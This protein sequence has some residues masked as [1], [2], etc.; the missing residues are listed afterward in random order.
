M[1]KLSSPAAAL[2]EKRWRRKYYRIYTL[3]FW[4]TALIVYACFI[5]SGY[6]LIWGT[7]GWQQHFKALCYY[8]EY[9]RRIARTLL[10]E[11]RLV[12]PNWDFTFGEG[13][14]VLNTLHYYVI[15][16]PIAL[17]SALVPQR[18]MHYF[19]SFSCVLRMYLAG[20]A[21]SALAI[22]TGKRNRRGILAGA[23][24]YAFCMWCLLD[25]ARH[26]YFLN[27][28]I[29][30]PLL[31][32]GIEKIVRGRRPYLFI[33][34]AA[35]SAASNFYFFYMIAI[36]G[37]LY[38]LVRLI[39]LREQDWKQKLGLLLRMGLYAVLGVCI[40]GVILLPVILMFLADSRASVE[41]SFRLFY[42]FGYYATLPA[43]AVSSASPYW[44]QGGFSAPMV[45]AVAA[46][47]IRK[48]Q[49]RVLRVC[50]V[51]FAVF[52]LFPIFGRLL[53]GMSYM[54]N[55]WSWAIPLLGAYVLADQWDGLF[56]LSRKELRRLLCV[57]LAFFAWMI[58][59]D[60]SRSVLSVA[61]T[62]L[63]LLALLIASGQISFGKRLRPQTIMV[64]L[65]ACSVSLI[66]VWYY[67]PG[68]NNYMSSCIRNR[69][70]QSRREHNEAQAVLD[71][72]YE[73]YPR[74]SGR[75]LSNNA[76]MDVGISSTQYYWSISNPWLSRY[77]T[78]LELNESTFSKTMRYDERTVPLTL[79]GV[80]YYTYQ[81]WDERPLPCGFSQLNTVWLMEEELEE[82][83]ER[84]RQE[85]GVEE[86]SPELEEKLMAPLANSRV[87]IAHT[88]YAMPLGYCY[89]TRLTRETWEGL[90]AVQRQQIQLDA[91]CL[92]DPKGGEIASVLPEYDG[93]IPE[94]SLPYE[95]KCLSSAV[96]QTEDGFVT[97]S[98]NAKVRL[99]FR[100]VPNAETYLRVGGFSFVGSSNAELYGSDP[101][102]DPLDLYNQ[103]FY[104][105]L[106]PIAKLRQRK[107][108]VYWNDSYSFTVPVV[109]SA[110]V[111]KSLDI[112]SNDATFSSGR[113]DL[114]LNLGW[115]EEAVTSLTISFPNV[116]R[117]SFD[118]LSVYAAPMDELGEKID[119]LRS[120]TLQNVRE[121]TD[122][123]TG[124]IVLQQPKLLVVAIPYSAGWSALVDGAPAQLLL[125]NGR[126]LG[127][128]LSA[129]QHEIE[130]HYATPCLRLGALVSLGGLL[131]FA[132][133]VLAAERR[134][135]RAK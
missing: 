96:T 78:E 13:S 95:V 37:V 105:T 116:G 56:R 66:G 29:W 117:Y 94:Y 108:S 65:A 107:Q 84:L 43:T 74:Y 113:S 123:L 75:V 102:V 98:R 79:A 34:A 131:V 3:A 120:D 103:T 9:L 118:D 82:R 133:L 72:A 18:W 23:L 119:A 106:S 135:K 28:L 132:L 63:L 86:L 32:L 104:D 93:Q 22:G 87:D 115:Q 55:R 38:A 31:I 44:V 46:L 80:Q 64:L 90:N 69:D 6:S 100:G 8:G 83:A 128:E 51:I 97:T 59:S 25:A 77:K 60:K 20:L 111:R 48:K 127:L 61:G 121:S 47:F 129:G 7:D 58:L 76:N 27:P 33:A 124:T 36:L 122:A 19:Y 5:R 54:S 42:P 16:D 134:R 109:S 30:F 24:S 1:Q 85:L 68:F 40:A 12:I 35:V 71:T 112:R 88:R 70:V 57:V 91:V 114:L 49:S 99:S 10:H 73:A 89:D 39:L 17:L 26:P 62:F 45:L 21:F 2:T 50:C 52:L 92:E 4:L 125:A 81:I 15:G 126:Y 11:H 14:D 53:N 101:S 41:Q 67:A 130:L 110:G